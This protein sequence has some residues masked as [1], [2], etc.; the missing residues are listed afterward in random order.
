MD[1]QVLV[2]Q[3]FDMPVEESPNKIP[4]SQIVSQNQNIQAEYGSLSQQLE[5]SPLV[6]L[7][8]VHF[9]IGFKTFLKH[10]M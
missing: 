9:P 3:T 10:A 6:W 8:R 4:S 1:T 2:Q 5:G 7:A